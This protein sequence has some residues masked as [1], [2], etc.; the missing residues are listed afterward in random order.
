ML[1]S[2]EA[3]AEKHFQPIAAKL[4][5]NEPKV[6]NGRV[7]IIPGVKEALQAFA[8]DPALLQVRASSH[9]VFGTAKLP[10]DATLFYQGNDS[11]LGQL[12]KYARIRHHDHSE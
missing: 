2:A 10:A 1:D 9:E 6:V 8:D 11:E 3:I 7:E 12:S 4:D 5:A